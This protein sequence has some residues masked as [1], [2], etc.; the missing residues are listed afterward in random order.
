[1]YLFCILFIQFLVSVKEWGRKTPKQ[2]QEHLDPVQL[3]Q[4]VLTI[5]MFPEILKRDTRKP[6]PCETSNENS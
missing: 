5:L 1:M 6:V 3:W 4:Q 2:P